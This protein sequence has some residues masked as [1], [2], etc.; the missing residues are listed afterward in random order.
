[1][2]DIIPACQGIGRQFESGCPL[3]FTP[4]PWYTPQLAA[5]VHSR[6]PPARWQSGYAA[7]C[8]AVY[9]GSIPV[10]A[11]NSASQEVQKRFLFVLCSYFSGK[12]G[13]WFCLQRQAQYGQ[14]ICRKSP[15]SRIVNA[16]VHRQLKGRYGCPRRTGSGARLTELKAA[17]ATSNRPGLVGSR[18]PIE[19]LS[20][21]G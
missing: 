5:V 16:A 1:M 3:Q 2:P 18:F 15:Q 13:Q 19:W 7:A 4:G 21:W 12:T 20:D 10:L 8:K 17:A 14:G 6:V 11:S 9:V